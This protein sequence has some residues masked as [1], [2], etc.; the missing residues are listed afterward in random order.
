[1]DGIKSIIRP[2]AEEDFRDARRIMRLA[3]G[4]FSGVP[5]PAN[6]RSDLDFIATRWRADP[7]AAFA[8]EVNGELVGSNFAVRWGSFGF[9]GPL[10]VRPDFWDRGIGQQLMQPIM[11]CF[12]RWGIRQAGLFTFA[13]SPRHVALYQKFGFAARFLTAVLS[14]EVRPGGN[15][16]SWTKYSAAPQGDR[17]RIHRGCFQLTDSVH[18][19]LDLES[20][21]RTIH[22]QGLGDTVLFWKDSELRGFG[23]CHC[24]PDTEA[25]H[26]K[27][28]IKFAVAPTGPDFE[29][30]LDACEA[31]AVQGGLTHVDAGVN[32]ARHEAYQHLLDR[33]FRTAFQGVAMHRPNEAA[34]SRPGVYV[35]DDWR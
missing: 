19:G 27:C 21:I 11:E 2:L 35:I 9:F 8:A 18:P 32:L 10:T 25:G 28:Y 13:H 30:L 15:S 31:F 34:H 3:F 29:S 33:G 1:M 7:S 6:Y 16:L 17:E 12:A 22:A 20:E 24:G 4:T 26:N 23:V 5:D 14:K